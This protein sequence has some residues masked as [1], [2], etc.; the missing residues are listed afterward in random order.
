MNR[1]Q[2]HCATVR[3]AQGQ[4]YYHEISPSE[5]YHQHQGDRQQW[6]ESLLE[7]GD[8]LIKVRTEFHTR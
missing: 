4:I 1:I 5:L 7:Q 6:A 3:T 8:Q 2:S